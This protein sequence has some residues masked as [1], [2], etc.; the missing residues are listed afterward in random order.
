MMI[1]AMSWLDLPLHD[2]DVPITAAA[3][4]HDG[5]LGPGRRFAAAM[6]YSLPPPAD[7]CR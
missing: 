7:R 3:R 5:S 1:D 2:A 6:R 4:R